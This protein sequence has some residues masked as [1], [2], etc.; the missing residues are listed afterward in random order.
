MYGGGTRVVPEARSS[1]VGYKAYTLLAECKGFPGEAVTVFDSTVNVKAGDELVV[2]T[3][4]VHKSPISVNIEAPGHSLK[5]HVRPGEAARCEGDR[6]VLGRLRVRLS[7]A[8]LYLNSL[9]SVRASTGYALLS[10]SASLRRILESLVDLLEDHVREPLRGS[11]AV[12]GEAARAVSLSVRLSCNPH[13]V[14]F[15]RYLGIGQGFTP[16]SDDFV[17]GFTASWNAVAALLG[18]LN[19]I[20]PSVFV[21][22]GTNW[23]SYKLVENAAKLYLLEPLDSLLYSLLFGGSLEEAVDRAIDL[24]GVGHSSGLYILKGALAGLGAAVDCLR[25]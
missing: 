3:T 19:P 7:G 5:R 16:S 22:G 1:S 4:S 12:V 25:R 9:K 8:Q 6:L 18:A 14:D 15:S 10:G 23:V 11:G 2:V 24:A 17:L 21:G 20:P 13:E